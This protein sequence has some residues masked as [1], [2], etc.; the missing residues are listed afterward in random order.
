MNTSLEENKFEEDESGLPLLKKA[1]SLE[2]RIS[3]TRRENKVDF[4][5]VE[6]ERRNSDPIARYKQEGVKGRD[7]AA[8]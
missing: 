1:V 4:F 5:E 7:L 6:P 2:E 3:K 8:I